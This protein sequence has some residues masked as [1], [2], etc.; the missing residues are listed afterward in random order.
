MENK[1]DITVRVFIFHH[2]IHHAIFIIFEETT[3][4]D[5]VELLLR[6]S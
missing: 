1:P 6:L 4:L 5:M 2:A 3:Y